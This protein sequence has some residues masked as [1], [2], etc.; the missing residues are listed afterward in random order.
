MKITRRG[1]KAKLPSGTATN[2][3]ILQIVGECLPHVEHVPGHWGH[4]T[5]DGQGEVAALGSRWKER[6]AQ[7]SGE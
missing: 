4:R 7:A 6:V 1:S 3:F 5:D 2:S